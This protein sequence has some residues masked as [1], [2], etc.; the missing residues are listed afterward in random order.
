MYRQTFAHMCAQP[1]H[2]HT[3]TGHSIHVTA[4]SAGCLS[5]S[6]AQAHDQLLVELEL[7]SAAVSWRTAR[8][9]HGALS[10]WRT[11]AA[12]AA[13]Q[14]LQEAAHEQTWS[15]VRGWLSELDGGAQQGSGGRPST[16][17]YGSCSTMATLAGTGS[18][19]PVAS[20]VTPEAAA[21]A[22]DISGWDLDADFSAAAVG[23]THHAGIG[24]GH[25]LSVV[26]VA[27]GGEGSEAFSVH[28]ATDALGDLAALAEWFEAAGRGSKVPSE[29]SDS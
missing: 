16:G 27:V 11:N 4:L 9:Q 2:R 21:D 5:V 13:Q 22:L 28:G 6:A 7:S 1:C 15:R 29:C 18:W 26:D 20:S 10:T 12:E 19:A 3:S 24:D 23:A 8:L 25:G 17:A 14:R